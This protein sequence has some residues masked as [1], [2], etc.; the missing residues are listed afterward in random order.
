MAKVSYPDISHWDQ[1]LP[2]KHSSG[3]TH[4]LWSGYRRSICWLVNHCTTNGNN[5]DI[6]MPP[7]LTG[8]AT[9]MSHLVA[10]ALFQQRVLHTILI[11]NIEG[12]MET[13]QKLVV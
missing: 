5:M 6:P 4:T 10:D 12:L 2:T 11:N 3:V 13:G 1:D 8:F 7:L 9:G